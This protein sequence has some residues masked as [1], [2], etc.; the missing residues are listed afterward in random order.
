MVGRWLSI[1]YCALMMLLKRLFQKI[2]LGFGAVALLTLSF[3]WR[4]AFTNLIFA[5][6]DTFLYFYPYWEYRAQSLLAGRLP[7]WNPYLFMGAPFLANSQAGVLYPFNW[8]LIFFSAPVAVKISLTLHLLLAAGG[9]YLFARRALHQSSLA[10]VL[11]AVVFALGGYLTA[12]VEHVNQLQGLAWFPTLLLAI[13][14]TQ[15][16]KHTLHAYCVL[17][18]VYSLILLTGHTQSAFIALTGALLYIL[19]TCSPLHLF[20]SAPKLSSAFRFLPFAIAFCLSLLLASAQLLPTLELSQNSLRGGGLPLREALSFSLDPR[21]IGRALLPSYSRSLFS[22]FVAYSGVIGLALSVASRCWTTPARRAMLALGVVGLLGALGVYNPLYALLANFPPF[23]LFRVPARWLF[24][25]AFGGALLA[26]AGLDELRLTPLRWRYSLAPLGLIGWAFLSTTLT[27]PGETGP[28]GLPT[29][30]D[31]IGWFAPLVVLGAVS[32]IPLPAQW[33][34]VSLVGCALLELFC[35]AQV[36]PYNHLTTPDAYS[37]LR[38]AMLQLLAPPDAIPPSASIPNSPILQSS[39]MVTTV[40]SIFASPFNFNANGQPRP[41]FLSLSA[42][43]FDPGDAAELHSALDPQLP[44]DAVYD[45][46]IATKHKEVLSPNLPLAWNVPAVDGYD[47][48]V[49]PLKHYATFA[50]LFTGAPSADGRLRENLSA[51]PDQRWLTLANVRYL[52]TDKVNDAWV[53]DVFYDL[54]FTLSLTAEQTA[55]IAVVPEFQ[56]TALGVVAD[57]LT[58]TV[59]MTFTDGAPLELPLTARRLPFGRAAIPR[60]ITLRG[61]LTVHGLSLIDERSGAF[62]SLTLGDYRL[63]HSGDVKIYENLRWRDLPRA[64]VVASAQV[65]SDDAA[66]LTALAAPSFDP[67][68]AVILA[69]GSIPQFSTPPISTLPVFTHYE[70]EHLQLTATGP[71]YLV[72]ADAD[73]PGWVATVDEQ[74]APIYRADILFRAIELPAGTHTIELRFEPWSVRIGLWVSGVAWGVVGVM[75]LW[76]RKGAS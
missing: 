19:F 70:P 46:I 33:R 42:L 76:G 65:I 4:V 40:Q 56:A 75:L 12:Q 14:H 38:P 25:L 29:S 16:S 39:N 34:V 15:S 53:E 73:Y 64:F 62:Q 1:E 23:N 68:T 71:G 21:L 10:A 18:M 3:F 11:A 63:V 17:S 35:A 57:D 32:L 74:P 22:E 28:L 24:L 44:P 51:V 37:S 6:G 58:G 43:R 27:P 66:A 36:L 47:G 60:A 26:G 61:P 20:T 45:A 13:H 9:T 67:A 55:R 5:R 2:D 49:L 72:L 54:Q 50:A 48:G 41:R 52:I 30:L 8:P 59:Q 7:L 31:L 69:A